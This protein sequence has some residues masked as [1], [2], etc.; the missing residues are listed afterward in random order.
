MLFPDLI[1][2]V[3]VPEWQTVQPIQAKALVELLPIILMNTLTNILDSR[4]L[5]YLLNYIPEPG[6]SPRGATLNQAHQFETLLITIHTKTEITSH[7][8]LHNLTLITEYY[9]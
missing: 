2:T 4:D 1:Q 3:T 6:C 8:Q 9:E 5:K 7:I